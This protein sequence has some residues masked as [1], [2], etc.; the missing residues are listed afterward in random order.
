MA[1]HIIEVAHLHSNVPCHSDCGEYCVA[2]VLPTMANLAKFKDTPQWAIADPAHRACELGH[3]CSVVSD[4]K[5]CVRTI[6]HAKLNHAYGRCGPHTNSPG[7]ALCRDF[8]EAERQL[9]PSC[10]DC[11][12]LVELKDL[13][14]VHLRL[15]EEEDDDLFLEKHGLERFEKKL[16][17]HAE[18]LQAGLSAVQAPGGFSSG[19]CQRV[20]KGIH[21]GPLWK[22]LGSKLHGVLQALSC[23]K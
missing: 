1:R 12:V 16:L 14:L 20:W 23:A 8:S 19:D 9:Y 15:L 2:K 3:G 18:D 10:A 5:F 17:E 21:A 6:W 7:H 22:R 13:I 11:G 4:D